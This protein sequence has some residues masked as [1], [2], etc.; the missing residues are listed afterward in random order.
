MARSSLT[1]LREGAPPHRQYGAVEHIICILR[2]SLP[3]SP[4]RFRKTLRFIDAV[5]QT[6]TAAER[7]CLEIFS[8]TALTKHFRPSWAWSHECPCDVV[9]RKN[10]V[11]DYSAVLITETWR[12]KER[13]KR[14]C[15]MEPMNSLQRFRSTATYFWIRDEA[16]FLLH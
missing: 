16:S 1:R 7:L 14:A 13:D 3:R 5:E 12:R 9:F 8:S 15:S 11:I 4:D 2:R 6:S 10:A